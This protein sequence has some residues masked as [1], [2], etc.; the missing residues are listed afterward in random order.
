MSLVVLEAGVRGKPVLITDTCGFND[1]EAVGGGMVVSASVDGLTAGL[2]S[3][4]SSDASYSKMGA[5]L[6]SFVQSSFNWNTIAV[7]YIKI[8]DTNSKD[9]SSIQ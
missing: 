1:V 4:M 9:V 6:K 5:A 2:E 7:R 3:F 8:F